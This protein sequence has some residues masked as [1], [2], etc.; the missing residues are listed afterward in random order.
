MATVIAAAPL[1]ML[2][3]NPWLGQIVSATLTQVV[4]ETDAG[5]TT[6][7]EGQFQYASNGVPYGTVTGFSQADANGALIAVLGLSLTANDAYSLIENGDE[8]AVWPLILSQADTIYGSLVDD[9]LVGFDGN[10]LFIPGL[11]SDTIFG[12][13]GDDTVRY[14]SG[15]DVFNGEEGLDKIVLSLDQA[16]ATVNVAD[17]DTFTISFSGSNDEVSIN[18]VERLLFSN[19]AVLALDVDIGENAG[20]AYRMY[21]AALNRE[22]DDQGLA[23]WINFLDHGGAPIDMASLFIASPEFNGL[24]GS[25]SNEA[26]VDQL[27]INVLDREG[28]PEGVFVWTNAL[29]SGLSRSQVLLGFSESPENVANVAPQ[30]ET[31]ISYT[32]WWAI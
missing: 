5:L 3:P 17:V 1:D 27:Y 15:N 13:H 21:E 16:S 22:P 30:I 23:S 18:A 26:F 28:E 24:Y 9:V 11:G 19:N 8:N 20:L 25:L 7:L 32:E 31:G 4:V 12:G 29:N 6:S 14:Q 10:D 2:S